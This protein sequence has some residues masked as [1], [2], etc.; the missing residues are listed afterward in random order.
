M[1]DLTTNTDAE[2]MTSD[3]DMV[4]AY[5]VAL[6][7]GRVN[8]HLNREDLQVLKDM[9]KASGAPVSFLIR[10]AIRDYIF[11]TEAA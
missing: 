7:T 8:L 9:S 3:V 10:K 1:T 2:V 6:K 11:K 5:K 4:S